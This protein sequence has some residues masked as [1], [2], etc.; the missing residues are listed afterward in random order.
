MVAAVI[1]VLHV[2]AAG[3]AFVSRR[4]KGG[5]GE[6]LLAVAFVGII[7]SVGWTIM[8]IVTSLLVDP[9]GIAPW[10]DRDATT[11]ALLTGAEGVFYYFLLRGTS[12][13]RYQ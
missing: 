11:L 7:F 13:N 12:G 8:T 10:L 1:L 4:K 5:T 9:E 6:G 3:V 2:V